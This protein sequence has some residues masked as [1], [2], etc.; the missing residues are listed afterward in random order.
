MTNS[1]LSGSG[2]LPDCPL[3]WEHLTSLFFNILWPASRT[4]VPS[5]ANLR[6]AVVPFV[7]SSYTYVLQ[8]GFFKVRFA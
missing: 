5:V 3:H 1:L 4:A 7:H 8:T 2:K 6:E